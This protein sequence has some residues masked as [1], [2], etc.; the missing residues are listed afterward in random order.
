[1][2][3][4]PSS[5]AQEDP[6]PIEL[7]AEAFAGGA[8]VTFPAASEFSAGI[9]LSI[10]KHLGYDLTDAS[11]DV[12]I[13]GVSYAVLCWRPDPSLQVSLSPIG[14]AGVVGNDFGAFYPSARLGLGTFWGR[15]GVG[16]EMRLVRIA[17]GHGSGVYWYHWSPVRVSFRL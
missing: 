15:F 2:S 13:Y 6:G 7:H 14:I 16:T 4:A 11:H 17:S 5:T 3:F 9:D 10:G 12:T 8:T 1:M